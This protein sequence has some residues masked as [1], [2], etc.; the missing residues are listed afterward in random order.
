MSI[1][2]EPLG[3]NERRSESLESGRQ[4]SIVFPYRVQC[5]ACGFQPMGLRIPP[6]RCEKCNSDSWER[7]VVPRSLLVNAIAAAATVRNCIYRSR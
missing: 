3:S 4:Q 7:F 5:R 6:R 2:M 1:A